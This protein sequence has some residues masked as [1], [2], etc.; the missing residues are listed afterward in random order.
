[1]KI[2]LSWILKQWRP[3]D[4]P[5]NRT[6]EPKV[7][8][9]HHSLD[10]HRCRCAH[11]IGPGQRQRVDGCWNH[12]HHSRLHALRRLHERRASTGTFGCRDRW[13]DLCVVRPVHNP[14]PP[15]HLRNNGLQL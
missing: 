4:G 10:S 12:A 8:A 3:E 13:T 2:R 7:V 15:N 14:R 5:E 6:T 9:G 1:M 11:G